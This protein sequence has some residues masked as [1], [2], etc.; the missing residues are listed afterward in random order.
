MPAGAR[1][2]GRGRHRPRYRRDLTV[3]D[4]AA[5]IWERAAVSEYG[6]S[7]GRC[8]DCGTVVFW[9][10]PER[11]TVSFGAA[12]V[13]GGGQLEVAAH[14]WVPDGERDALGPIG[15]PVEPKGLPESVSVRWEDERPDDPAEAGRRGATLG[16]DGQA[17]LA[18]DR[19]QGGDD[20]RDVLVELEP[21]QLGTGVDLVAV[22]AGGEGRLLQLLLDRLRLEA[23]E[24]G[25]P[26]EPAGVDEPGELVAGEERLLQQRLARDLEV[27]G[28]R[29]HGQDQHLGVALLAE[30][31][32]AVLRMLVERGVDLVVEVVEERRAAPQLLVLAEVAGVPAGRRL[33][34]QRVTEQ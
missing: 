30:D 34:G 18:G 19:L 17:E 15:V 23:L 11:D 29:E 31:R 2:A 1:R 3:E 22:D 13:E 32:R 4:D 26:H 27:L 9:D 25:R 16:G 21:E 28:M 14:I 20:V 33:H 24:P 6:A 10:A 7:R 12:L 5:L 8:R